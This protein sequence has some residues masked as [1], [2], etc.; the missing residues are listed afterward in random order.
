MYMA[1]LHDDGKSSPLLRTNGM[2]W[3]DWYGQGSGDGV[4]RSSPSKA[5][6]ASP[7]PISSY[8][9]LGTGATLACRTAPPYYHRTS[10]SGGSS[11]A[12]DG[13]R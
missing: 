7:V 2:K 11:R 13:I 9:P 4:G 10:T 6:A 5:R 12:Y 8:A 3:Y 1:L